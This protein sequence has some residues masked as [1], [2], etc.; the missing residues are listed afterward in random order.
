MIR[1]DDDMIKVLGGIFGL[2]LTAS[3][4]GG[5]LKRALKD[6]AHRQLIENLN[7]R[8]KAWW[9][10]CTVFS[11]ALLT[12]GIGSILLFGFV[13]FS[14]L[15]EFITLT[16]TRQGD[17]RALFWAFFVILPF[18]YYLIA[19]NWYGMFSILIPVYAFIFLPSRSVMR[20][21]YTHFLERTAKIQ[22]GL[23]LCVYCI[24]HAPALLT[25]QIPG[26]EGQSAKLLFFLVFVV[27]INDVG[28][29]ILGKLFGKRKIAPNISPNK[30]VEGFVGGTIAATILGT[31]LWWMTPFTMLQAAGFSLLITL[32]GFYG[33]LTMSAIKRDRG[34]KDFGVMIEGHGGVLDR[35]DS[36]CFSAPIFFHLVRYYFASN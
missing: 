10:M 3:L 1:I 4:V 21:D 18:Q 35:I 25:L 16:P 33:G 19:N 29:Y 5:I 26:Y 9:I 11:L 31:L 2:L 17:H 22:W 20:G 24:S 28:Q 27:E 12:G 13:S 14:A 34:I 15:R 30:T 23:M 8:I 7:A 32:T 36:L 6:E